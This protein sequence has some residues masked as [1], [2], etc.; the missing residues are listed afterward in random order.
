MV[1]G[2]TVNEVIPEPSLTMALGK[3]R[4]AIDQKTTVVWEE[5]SDYHSGR[6]VGEVSV[7]PVFDDKGACTHLVGSVH[8]ITDRKRA[9]A[10][11]RESEKRLRRAERLAHMGHWDLDIKTSCVHWSEEMFRILGQPEG[12]TPSFEQSFEIVVPQDRER[13][14]QWV[15]DC[16]AEKKG[17]SIELQVTL[18]NGDVRTLSLICEI[19]LDEEGR[20]ARLFGSSQDVTETRRAQDEA[21]AR[22]RLE[23]VG[24]LASGIAHDFN[25]LLGAVMAQAELALA[26][27]AGRASPEEQL[28]AIRDVAMRGAEI[29]RELMI[30]AG[31]EGEVLGLVDV[32]QTVEGLLELLRISVSKHARLETDLGQDLPAIHASAAQISQL[33]MNLAMNAS[34]AI[35][36]RDGVI[37]VTTQRAMV[38]H[39]SQ[40]SVRLAEGEYVQLEVS[41]TGRGMSPETQARV[42]DPFFSTKSH[43]RGL[44]L[45]VVHGIVR[46]LGGTISLA[47]EP[48]HGTTF[49][50]LL[51]CAGTTSKAIRGQISEI[52]QPAQTSEPTTVLVVEDETAM[53]QAVS[54]MLCKHGFSVIEARDGSAALDTIRGQKEPIDVLFLD[55]TLPGASSREVSKEA[56]RLRPDMRVIVT[57]AYT[58]EMAGASLQ[59]TIE[60]FIRKP[61]RLDDLVGL[62]RRT[63]PGPRAASHRCDSQH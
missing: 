62:I 18:P 34:E 46:R 4:Q 8:D 29:V 49:Q 14:D 28:K 24:T 59:S 60:H 13:A 19:L 5:T 6:L 50:V 2:K 27:L 53:R 43:G 52:G 63:H 38:A 40:G 47:S 12:S 31:N 61:Y 57:S 30:Y 26:E 21:S 22:Q 58:E 23:S 48:G 54:K 17:S 36:G 11:L 55:I 32:S 42:F 15:R 7:A 39:G 9:E 16:L 51:P 56:R 1:V 44:G 3:Y 10:A 20:P 25:N 45:A 35:G 33:V 41:D 37:R